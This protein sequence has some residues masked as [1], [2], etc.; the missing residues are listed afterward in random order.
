MR[1][2]DNLK[3][4]WFS[5]LRIDAP[6]RGPTAPRR[7]K[8][9]H[10]EPRQLMTGNPVA[11][12][13]PAPGTVAPQI[14]V[15]STYLEPASGT[16][17]IPNTFQ[18]TFQGGAPGTQLTHLEINGSKNG[19]PL[20]FNDVIFDTAAGGIGAYGFNP[21]NIVSHDGFQILDATA[22]DGST[23]LTMDFSGFTAGMKLVFTV[24]VDQ[25]I[26]V[27]P[28]TVDAVAEGAEFEGSHFTT[29]FTA[30]HYQDTQITSTYVDQFDPTF[31]A[32]EQAAGATLN[33][34]DD[35]YDENPSL[36]V[37]TA[38]AIGN[39]SA[40][41]LPITLSGRVYSDTNQD[42]QQES[43][44]PGVA[45]ATVELW[46]WNG[47]Q[48]VDTGV[49]ET[50]DAAG[51]YSFS[52][53]PPGK[54]RVVLATPSGYFAEAATPG[55]VSGT[56]DG[57]AIT[58]TTISEINLLGGDNSQQNNFALVQPVTLSGYVYHDTNSDGQ[59]ETGEEGLGGVQIMIVPVSTLAGASVTAQT[60][61]TAA[62]GSYSVSGLPPG[63]YNI[64][65]VTQPQGY[66][67]GQ[68]RAGNRGG[69]AVSP[70][71]QIVNIA[72]T[73]G[74]SSDENDFGKLL[75]STIS[76]V[77]HNDVNGDCETNPNEPVVSGVTIELLSASGTV[78]ATTT[79]NAQGAYTFT[80]LAQGDYSV[81]EVPSAPWL[82]DDSHVGTAG[83][84]ILNATEVDDIGL[85]QGVAA[86]NYNF[87]LVLPVS[88][89]GIVHNDVDGDC[90]TNPNEPVLAGVTVNLLDA[91]GKVIATTVT[92]SQ[93]AYSF[94]GLPPG[95]YGVTDVALTGYEFDDAHVGSSGGVV[96][97]NHL[98]D[99]VVLTSGT[100]ATS[101]NFCLDVSPNPPLTPPPAT[102]P[103][104][105]QQSIFVPS[106]PAANPAPLQPMVVNNVAAAIYVQQTS[107]Q[108]WTPSPILG[109]SQPTYTWHL[110]VV[111]AGQPRGNSDDDASI[112][113]II[114]TSSTGDA[115]GEK[116]DD[117]EWLLAGGKRDARQATTKKVVFGVHEGIPISGDFNGDGTVDVGVFV[118][119]NWYLDVNGNGQW[120]HGDLFAKLGRRGD[121]PVTGD[122]D[123]DGKT[124][125]GIYGPAWRG[126]AKALKREPGLP[127]PHN[128]N[129]AVHKNVPP[130]AH[131][132]ADEK[133][134]LKFNGQ[135][136]SRADVVDH[137]FHYGSPQDVPVA[138][139]WNGDGTSTIAI[140]RGGQWHF[141][142]NG[143]GQVGGTDG[144]V[145]FGQAG[146][147]PV[148][149]DWNGDGTTDVGVYRGGTWYLDTNGNHQLDAD[150]EVVQMGGE[151]DRPIAGDW[152]GDGRHEPALYQDAAATARVPIEPHR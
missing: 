82:A 126:D 109:S 93:G 108:L 119:G 28:V 137:V 140:F 143:D 142:S 26:G 84:T 40:T 52:G 113:M 110:S 2:W 39:Q 55:N 106:S 64:V 54:Y 138:G 6:H 31:A 41:P 4:S 124:D 74:Q 22:N 9:E 19:G 1:L 60:V 51:D 139:D 17:T 69:T 3:R 34:P 148:A 24:D 95:T 18:I 12:I 10:M 71:D 116:L 62:D 37:L 75:P 92:N 112:A 136:K 58:A 36:A 130:P 145:K 120:D 77:V 30:P 96:E 100:D 129:T 13:N 57:A 115:D 86:V 53:L 118:D 127:D 90:E 15:G 91:N 150:D 107:P 85:S 79:T 80:G 14:L 97:N 59:R 11:A 121:K 50:T 144:V 73:S 117:A 87:C 20:T 83:G 25:V 66:L 111:D 131:V 70:G 102:P 48:Y 35:A 65:E 135:A 104:A 125:I 99:G 149:G 114:N 76:G 132:A 72:L 89:A 88:I 33:L 128:L 44:E 46:Q 68:A 7:C 152:D 94:N 101:Y 105:P 32:A 23:L 103:T 42:V 122:W 61:T 147:Q 98:T 47:T 38:G 5:P 16:D 43:G 67:D 123:G 45:G 21:I 146:D 133:R 8:F 78:V 134:M 141:D 151:H 63:T 56:S 49:S 81:R 29:T 27:N